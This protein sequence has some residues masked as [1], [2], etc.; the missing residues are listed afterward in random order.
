MSIKDLSCNQNPD[1]NMAGTC[2]KEGM[3][4]GLYYVFNI[5]LF[6][7][8]MFPLFWSVMNSFKPPMEAAASP[9]TYLMTKIST[10]NFLKFSKYGS[11]VWRY[12]TNSGIVSI[13]TVFGAIILSTLAGYGFSRFSFRG[14]NLTFVI[15]LSTMMIPFQ[16]I[17]IPLFVVFTR[18]NL[19]NSLFG[20]ILIY[21]TFQLPFGVFIMRNTFDMIPREIEEAALIDGCNSVNLLWYVML[22]LVSPGIVTI[23]ISAFLAAWNEFII[24]LIMLLKDT[25]YT[26]PILLTSIRTGYYGSIDWGA[27]QAGITVTI[28]PSM[29]LFL[30]LQRYYIKGLSSGAVK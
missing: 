15:L 30:L 13:G 3:R 2:F 14:K 7:L 10:D 25:K 6:L 19:N 9:P 26:L 22:R 11:G 24:A 8:F 12:F 28:V 1:Y 17:L 23:A 20:L 29:I 27:L 21:I 5:L 4:T 18:I 16:S